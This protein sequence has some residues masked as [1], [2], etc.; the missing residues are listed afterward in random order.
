MPR[1]ITVNCVDPDP[2]DTGYA[3]AG[4]RVA[5]TA[6]N[7]G[8][9]WRLV[10]RRWSPR[11]VRKRSRTGRSRSTRVGGQVLSSGVLPVG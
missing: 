3:D 5:V 4:T 1:R 10:S 7:P 9:R 6:R 8:G 11:S 2:N